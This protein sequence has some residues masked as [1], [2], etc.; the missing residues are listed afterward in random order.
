M[1]SFIAARTLT[2]AG[3]DYRPGDRLPVGSLKSSSVAALIRT[4]RVIALDENGVPLSRAVAEEMLAWHR[5]PA[6]V[7]PVPAAKARV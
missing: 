4:R 1:T 7:L 3:A 6:P 2:I 5:P